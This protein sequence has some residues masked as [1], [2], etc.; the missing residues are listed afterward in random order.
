MV[1]PGHLHGAILGQ[2][3][4]YP[5]GGTEPGMHRTL[6]IGH[7][8]YL[9]RIL[10]IIEDDDT[11]EDFED[12]PEEEDFD[13]DFVVHESS[14]LRPPHVNDDDSLSL[15]GHVD[16]LAVEDDGEPADDGSD[17]ELEWE[18]DSE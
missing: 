14:D 3:T 10:E 18:E 4:N 17:L 11:E 15:E 6:F 7:K 13:E 12:D 9:I 1:L 2:V 8:Q 5:A 16:G